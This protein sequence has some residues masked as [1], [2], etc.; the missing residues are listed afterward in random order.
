MLLCTPAGKSGPFPLVVAVH[1][2]NSNKAQVCGQIASPLA[3]RG[4]AVLAPDMP[5]HGERPGNWRDLAEAKDWFGAIQAHRRAVIDIRQSID[6]AETL[7]NIDLSHGVILAGYSMGSW[8]DSVVGPSDA[9]VKAMVLMVGGATETAGL[10][11]MIPQLVGADPLL[12][13]PHFAGP[14]LLL[15]GKRDTTVT[16]DMAQRLY[17]AAPEPK[18]QRWYDSG[19]RLPADAYQDAAEWIGETYKTLANHR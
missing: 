9:R 17:A 15:N 6:V 18:S 10:V 11:K 5:M 16:P 14:L 2:M 13:L 12:A 1:G 4:F 3:K 8:L 19:H 7:P